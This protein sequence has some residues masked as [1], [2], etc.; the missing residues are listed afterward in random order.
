MYSVRSV[1]IQFVLE[2]SG[3]RLE[4]NKTDTLATM[5][6]RLVFVKLTSYLYFLSSKIIRC[7][8]SLPGLQ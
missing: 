3:W 2:I 5:Y 4:I 1:M 6:K 7:V 8:N